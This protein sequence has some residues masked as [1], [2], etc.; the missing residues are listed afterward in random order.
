VDHEF[1]AGTPQELLCCACGAGTYTSNIKFTN[2]DVLV[3][4]KTYRGYLEMKE[5]IKIR[6]E[7]LVAFIKDLEIMEQTETVI[8]I[9]NENKR[10]LAEVRAMYL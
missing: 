5:F 10:Q 4:S 8:A 2:L 7:K 1:S 3:E 9:I 6:E